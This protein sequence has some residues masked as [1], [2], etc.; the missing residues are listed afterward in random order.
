[1][2]T[3]KDVERLVEAARTFLSYGRKCPPSCPCGYDDAEK[4]LGEALENVETFLT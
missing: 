3:K 4:E 1:M 2:N